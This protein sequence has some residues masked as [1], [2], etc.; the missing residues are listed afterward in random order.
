MTLHIDED[1]MAAAQRAAG[2]KSKTK[3]IVLA[4]ELLIQAAARRR[5]A[6]L[7]GAIAEAK[8]PS[9]QRTGGA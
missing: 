5:V 3:V 9:R 6:G 8:A 2:T 1:L 4:L 7:H